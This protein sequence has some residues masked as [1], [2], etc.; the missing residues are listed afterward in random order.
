MSSKIS[1]AIIGFLVGVI[2]T[3]LFFI[4]GFPII[5]NNEPDINLQ[6]EISKL[7]DEHGDSYSINEYD[8]SVWSQQW[9]ESGGNEIKMNSWSD[10]KES[11]RQNAFVF[12]LMVD[13]EEQVVWFKPTS[14][15][16]VYYAVR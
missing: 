11:L 2:L 8:W 15:N 16:I 14:Q 13:Y 4:Y 6:E 5:Q 10:F 3:S 9:K 12:L 1:Y 7:R